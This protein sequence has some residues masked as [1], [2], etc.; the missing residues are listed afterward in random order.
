MCKGITA[1]YVSQGW[2]YAVY[3]VLQWGSLSYMVEQEG[4]GTAYCVC[5]CI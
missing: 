3:M 4:I 1:T 2:F 5:T